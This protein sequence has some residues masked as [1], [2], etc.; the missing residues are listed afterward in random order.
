[1]AL[2]SHNAREQ[3]SGNSR[4][5]GMSKEWVDFTL[6][7]NVEVE[8]RD[9][10]NGISV[11]ELSAEDTDADV[12]IGNTEEEGSTIM[13]AFSEA[14]Q[15]QADDFEKF[16][17]G[18]AKEHTS[19]AAIE[20]VSIKPVDHGTLKAWVKVRL[21]GAVEIDNCKIVEPAGKPPFFAL[22]ST[23]YVDKDGKTQY[24][25]IVKLVKPGLKERVEKAVLEAW[26]EL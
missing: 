23:L 21:S 12:H 7:S 26:S 2:Y 19:T 14:A 8:F 16:M 3:E 1:M 24:N 9:E 15:K 17:Q 25:Q 11:A 18:P 22:P 4:M 6:V 10:G 20:I 5:N 13:T